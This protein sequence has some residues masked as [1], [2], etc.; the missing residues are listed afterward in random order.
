[1]TIRS[2]TPV[3][4][5][6]PAAGIGRRMQSETPKQYLQFQGKTILEHCLDRLLSN[7]AIGGA[8][9]VLDEEDQRWEALGYRAAKP[10]FTTT[11]GLERQ[12]SVYNGLTTLQHRQGN[13]AIV[14]VHDAARPLVRD[15]DLARVI[16]AARSHE[17]GAI[18]ATPV[19][20]TLK[21]EDA[22]QVISTTLSRDRLWRAMT[23]Q[24][25]HLQPLLN[26]LKQAIDVSQ[27]VTDDAAAIEAA[28]YAPLLVEGSM[29]N[30]KITKPED[31]AL[32]EQIWLYQRNQ[33]NHE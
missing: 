23:P 14:V 4:A 11:G 18:L 31:L 10:L 16:E 1:M 9:L 12:H 33:S 7:K 2:E 20:D 13:D 29:D 15:A 6:I 17:A 25:F 8:I 26:A 21:L 28:G 22:Q 30:L 27:T 5:V 3:W 32:A 19:V 24:V